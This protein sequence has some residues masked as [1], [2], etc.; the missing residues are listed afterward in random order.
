MCTKPLFRK[1]HD[2]YVGN[3]EPSYDVLVL[4]V[5]STR[6]RFFLLVKT[7]LPL[8]I[9]SIFHVIKVTLIH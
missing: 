5:V 3:V 4:L 1:Y 8:L 9:Y 7:F 2:V 6:I